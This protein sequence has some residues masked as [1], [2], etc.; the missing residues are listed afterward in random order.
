[1][2]EEWEGWRGRGAA[3]LRMAKNELVLEA[4]PNWTA[5]PSFSA[6]WA[7][8]PEAGRRR[9]MLKVKGDNGKGG[10]TQRRP[11]QKGHTHTPSPSK[12]ESFLGETHPSTRFPVVPCSPSTSALS[13]CCCMDPVRLEG[14]DPAVLQQIPPFKTHGPFLK[15]GGDLLRRF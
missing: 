11:L 1:M 12:V 14:S 6:C 2:G 5:G 13:V 7:R 4:R 10:R 15:R 3:Q 8:R 9:D